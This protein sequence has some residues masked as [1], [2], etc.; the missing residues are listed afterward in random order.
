M[1]NREQAVVCVL[2]PAG[3]G[4][5]A[6]VAVEGAAAVEAVDRYFLAANRR[7]LAEQPLDRI[8]YG[9]WGDVEDGEDLIVCRRSDTRIEVHC[10]G[11]QQSSAQ[12]V[13]DLAAA[14]C[15]EISQDEWLQI[16]QDCPLK[17]AA[18]QALS[19]ATTF[20]TAAI[21]L[22]QYHGAL[23][24]ELDAVLTLLKANQTAESRAKIAQ[25]LDWAEFGLHLTRP[26]QVVIAGRPNVGKSSLTN[27][28]V[29]FER[30]IVFDQP[31]TTR[32]IVTAT[33]AIDGWPIELSDTAGLHET[34]DSIESAGIELARARLANADLVVWVLDA[35]ELS[36]C[37]MDSCWALAVEQAAEVGV[38]LTAERALLCINKC[39]LIEP[40]PT[41]DGH[42]I[43]T[44]A[45]K[46]F[47]IDELL[48]SIAQ[49]LVPRVPE[50]G[51]AVPFTVAQM[52]TLQEVLKTVELNESEPAI[53]AIRQLL[54]SAD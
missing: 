32:D 9:H 22:D 45:T 24:R 18:L 1:T 47:G 36:S 49:Q 39:D 21:L 20:R 50:R 46:P 44:C 6:V 35:V 7:R 37:D 52:H 13:T 19:Q 40:T 43:L 14:G 34:D 15:K 5:V 23:R 17:A 30:A 2:T 10:H 48:D 25:L 42:A 29:G 53:R 51:T 3:R 16:E 31:G 12:I 26:W 54:N 33:T 27:A 28:L 41:R 4:A 11:G 8:V 38:Q